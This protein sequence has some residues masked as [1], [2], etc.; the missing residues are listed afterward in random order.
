MDLNTGN[1]L[2]NNVE[3]QA[4]VDQASVQL[5]RQTTEKKMLLFQHVEQ[6]LSLSNNN[7]KMITK[8]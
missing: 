6:L 4:L 5:F 1:N 3:N 7:D 2:S 8:I